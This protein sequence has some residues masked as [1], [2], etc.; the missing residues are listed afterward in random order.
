MNF[1]VNICDIDTVNTICQR[2]CIQIA[3]RVH[4]WDIFGERFSLFWAASFD[5]LEN[6]GICFCRWHFLLFCHQFNIGPNWKK[7]DTCINWTGLVWSNCLKLLYYKIFSRSLLWCPLRF[8]YSEHEKTLCY[9]FSRWRAKGFFLPPLTIDAFLS[10]NHKT[11][12]GF[13][14]DNPRNVQIQFQFWCW[15]S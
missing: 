1:E 7:N 2:F 12:F 3:R 8:P 5:R 14:L 4:V 11:I 9:T 10:P 15:L 13:T 6:H